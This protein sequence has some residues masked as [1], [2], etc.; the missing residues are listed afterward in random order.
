MAKMIV[1]DDCKRHKPHQAHNLC[2]ACYMRRW[3]K[4]NMAKM[5]I[6]DDCKQ[7]KPHRAHNLCAACYMRRWRKENPRSIPGVLRAVNALLGPMGIEC[8]IRGGVLYLRAGDHVYS[9]GLD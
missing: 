2:A 9:K 4:E 8:W 6:C 7:H 3:R 1:C 5:I